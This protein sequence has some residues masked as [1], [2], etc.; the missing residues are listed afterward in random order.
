MY[1]FGIL[2]LAL[3]GAAHRARDGPGDVKRRAGD[4][5]RVAERVEAAAGG[6]VA[7]VVALLV[8]IVME[9]GLVLDVGADRGADLHA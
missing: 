2:Y 8:V 5:S 9:R 3:E 6:Q 1:R 7:G 4:L